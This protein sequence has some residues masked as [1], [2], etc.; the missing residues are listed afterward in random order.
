MLVFFS[1]D[2]ASAQLLEPASC[3]GLRVEAGDER[4]RCYQAS[5]DLAGLISCLAS[6]NPNLIITSIGDDPSIFEQCVT[7][8]SQPPCSHHRSSDHYGGRLIDGGRACSGGSYAIDL[9]ASNLAQ[10]NPIIQQVTDCGGRAIF[11]DDHVHASVGSCGGS[12]ETAASVY[13]VT[14]K[15]EPICFQ[16][17]FPI[18][19]F[20]L[21][22][23]KDGNCP[24]GLIISSKGDA[25]IV[26]I[27]ALYKYGAGL[28]G[29]MAMFMIVFAAWQWIMASG[30]AGKIDNA[31]DTI[32]GSLLGLTLL[33]AG[34]LLLSNITTRLVSFNGLNIN[35]I[36]TQQLVNSSGIK[37]CTG[38]NQEQCNELSYMCEWFTTPNGLGR[39]TENHIC[40]VD[41]IPLMAELYQSVPDRLLCCGNLVSGWHIGLK[42]GAFNTCE[43]LCNANSHEEDLDT[44]FTGS[45]LSVGNNQELCESLA[46]FCVW[47][48]YSERCAAS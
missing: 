32:K 10:A 9:R 1:P 34:N 44:C 5:P 36:T 39:C 20:P 29:L 16:P 43:S 6:R 8:W 40:K 14:K 15:I 11:E 42:G 28:A 26:Y 31:K 45:C 23:E 22:D 3:N 37:N 27:N 7:N 30:N 41:T 13:S 17:A 19:G 2:L 46:P 38:L 25:I 24:N 35:N 12:G 21:N 18:P 47:S 33:F 48:P 4:D